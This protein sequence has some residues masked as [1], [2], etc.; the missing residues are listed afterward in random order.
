MAKLGCPYID[1]VQVEFLT[2]APAILLVIH[3]ALELLPFA[4]RYRRDPI[5][6]AFAPIFL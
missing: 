3:E 1:K 2:L 4:V 5:V 6:P